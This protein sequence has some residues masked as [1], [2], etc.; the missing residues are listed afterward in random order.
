MAKTR[1]LQRESSELQREGWGFYRVLEYAAEAVGL[2]DAQEILI[3]GRQ[4][5]RSQG[6]ALVCKWLA[7]DLNMKQIEIA[8]HLGISQA[9]VSRL[10]KRGR[11]LEKK[12]KAKLGNR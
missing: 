7:D 1:E 8:E 6:R 5:K 3:R 12:L 4:D 2:D 11:V 9:P 10:V